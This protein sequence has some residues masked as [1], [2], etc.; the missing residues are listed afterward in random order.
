[1]D[2]LPQDRVGESSSSA[3]AATAAAVRD[4]SLVRRYIHPPFAWT[5]NKYQ[6]SP[7]PVRLLLMSFGVM[8][9]V[10][11]GC[12]LGFMGVVTLGCLIVGGI[13]FAIVEGGFALFGSAFLLPALGVALLVACGM[14]IFSLCISL[15][16]KSA[17]Y[18]IGFF[19][20]PPLD[21]RLAPERRPSVSAIDRPPSISG[22]A[23]DK[24]PELPPRDH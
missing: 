11:V 1:M 13:A 22:R 14:G 8:S 18:V 3:V 4:S 20:S 23:R 10:P 19:R 12:F 2:A 9:V 17:N 7:R 21:P 5:V 16:Y 15:S 6:Q 24:A